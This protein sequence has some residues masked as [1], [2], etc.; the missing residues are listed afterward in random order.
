MQVNVG[1]GGPTIFG[2]ST[3]HEANTAD[4][5]TAGVAVAAI[6]REIRTRLLAAA[7]YRRGEAA[8]AR[9]NIQRPRGRYAMINGL[10]ALLREN[11]LR[12]VSRDTRSAGR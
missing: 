10:G 3:A 7:V 5:D 4:L 1:A 9:G 2:T 12:L 6:G 11:Q 8:C